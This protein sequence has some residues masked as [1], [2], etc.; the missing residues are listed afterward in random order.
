VSPVKLVP[1][2]L[3]VSGAGP[4]EG[5]AV[6]VPSGLAGPKMVHDG[7]GYNPLKVPFWQVL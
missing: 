5:L 1:E 2:K 4:E 3:T 6:N 7:Y